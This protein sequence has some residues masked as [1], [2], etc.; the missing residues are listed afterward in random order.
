[1][2]SSMVSKAAERSGR[3]RQEIFWEPMALMSWS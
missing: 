2:L 3:Q 1:M